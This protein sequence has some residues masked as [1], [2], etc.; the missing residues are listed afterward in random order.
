MAP[1][2]G[3]VEKRECDFQIGKAEWV[4]F[5]MIDKQTALI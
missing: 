4:T 3:F 1:F 5:K 2:H